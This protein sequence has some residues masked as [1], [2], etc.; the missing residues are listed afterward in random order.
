MAEVDYNSRVTTPRYGE[1]VTAGTMA[2]LKHLILNCV[3]GGNG[4]QVNRVGQSVVISLKPAPQGGGGGGNGPQVDY[5]AASKAL[6][7]EYT[8]VVVYARGRVISG[9][10]N[11]TAYIRNVANDGWVALNRLE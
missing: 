7:E 3:K 5:V 8:D 9:A 11:G 6:L 4:I 10:D 2:K 1:P